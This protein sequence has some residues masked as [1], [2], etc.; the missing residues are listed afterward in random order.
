M[1]GRC[2]AR[3]SCN[4]HGRLN[5][6]RG[7][8]DEARGEGTVVSG[9]VGQS[10]RGQSVRVVAVVSGG[11]AEQR[12]RFANGRV[13]TSAPRI[14]REQSCCRLLH[15]HAANHGGQ[16]HTKTALRRQH[17]HDHTP[18]T[19]AA[20]HRPPR[21]TASL[22]KQRA[23]EQRSESGMRALSVLSRADFRPLCSSARSLALLLCSLLRLPPPP[24]LLLLL[25]VQFVSVNPKPFLLELTGKTVV[26]KL[27]WGMEYK[28]TSSTTS[29]G[30]GAAE[31]A[32]RQSSRL[33]TAMQ[34]D[35]RSLLSLSVLP[36]YC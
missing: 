20:V 5:A 26:V 21:S 6:T 16:G 22:H 27:K 29:R 25:L 35:S 14:S 28:G 18:L 7:E 15:A 34:L 11:V 19:A 36:L 17:D 4:D 31:G 32:R 12:G 3:S 2:M 33:R 9:V 24:L 8:R 23:R 1:C 30:G 10:V 13:E